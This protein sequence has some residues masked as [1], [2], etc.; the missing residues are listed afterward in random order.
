MISY[1]ISIVIIYYNNI[2]IGRFLLSIRYYYIRRPYTR[3]LR[4]RIKSKPN[5][6][7]HE[8]HNTIIITDW[9]K[10]FFF[11]FFSLSIW[12]YFTVICGRPARWHIPFDC[13]VSGIVFFWNV[14]SQ[15]PLAPA[16]CTR[17]PCKGICLAALTIRLYTR[18][19]ITIWIPTYHIIF[20][21]TFTQVY[22]YPLFKYASYTIHI[23]Q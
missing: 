21:S 16:S 14:R 8:R 3:K 11:F 13:A 19:K 20:S 15:N 22:T 5:D 1:N 9:N 2:L 18:H 6:L 17:L 4:Q 10:W 23:F 7:R 12:Q